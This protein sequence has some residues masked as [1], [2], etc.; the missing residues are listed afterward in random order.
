[1]R[2]ALNLLAKLK[3]ADG[4]MELHDIGVDLADQD[5]I[6]YLS[7]SWGSLGRYFFA[8]PTSPPFPWDDMINGP[9]RLTA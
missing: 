3:A 9:A 8:E 6:H 7:D 4:G 2:I 5:L 1:M